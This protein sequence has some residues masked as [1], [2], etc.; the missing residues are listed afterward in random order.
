M[1]THQAIGAFLAVLLVS[2]KGAWDDRK[3]QK[4]K[5]QQKPADDSFAVVTLVPPLLL[6]HDKRTG[7]RSDAGE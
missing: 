3:A 1:E 2:L 4:L 5:E 7:R 6:T